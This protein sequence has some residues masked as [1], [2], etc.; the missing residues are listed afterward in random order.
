MMF[1][2]VSAILAV[3]VCMGGVMSHSAQGTESSA[4]NVPTK[5]VA[6]IDGFRSAKFGQTEAEVREAI[7]SDFGKKGNAPK[8]EANPIE[9]TTVLSVDVEN[10]LP[11]SG[12]ASVAYV[13]GFTSRKL[14]QVNV[15]WQGKGKNDPTQIA[16]ALS[17][18]FL[19]EEFKP[20]SVVVNAELPDH[21]IL[22]FRGTDMKGR[23]VVLE[24]LQPQDPAKAKKA[25]TSTKQPAAQPSSLR[26]SY[27]EK[28]AEP[29]I[30]KI[31]PGQF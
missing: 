14:I 18:Y 22:V 13:L 9:G 6:V 25:D 27:I 28:P 23:M 1:K 3:M 20:D 12:E 10:L 29:D 30:F 2:K 7:A 8:S 21:S 15:L 4:Q 11:N 26:L 17:N 16:L 5:P 24:L 19:G 31:K